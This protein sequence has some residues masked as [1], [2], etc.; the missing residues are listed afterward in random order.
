MADENI[1]NRVAA[2][3]QIASDTAA[4]LADIRSELRGLRSDLR[5]HPPT[6][7]LPART[8]L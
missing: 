8:G 2:L 4:V 1:S 6:A 3:E 7:I 5:I